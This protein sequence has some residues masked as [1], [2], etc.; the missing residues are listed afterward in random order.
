[1]LDRVPSAG[2]AV[3]TGRPAAVFEAELGERVLPVLPEEVLVQPGGEV[4][5]REH[6]VLVPVAVDG[7]LQGE[8][9]GSETVEPQVEAEVFRPLLERAAVAPHVLDDP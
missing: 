1:M 3:V 2:A 5:P 8:A 7:V 4:V 9:G 6:L